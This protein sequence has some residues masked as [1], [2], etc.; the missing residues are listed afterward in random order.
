MTKITSKTFKIN[1]LDLVILAGGKGTRIK[2]LLKGYPKPMLKFNGK[3]FLQYI[4]NLVIKYP[5]RNIYILTGYKSKIIISKYDK[6]EINFVKIKCLK[7]KKLLG[8]GGALFTLKKKLSNFVLINGDTLF[9]IDYNKLLNTSFKNSFGTIALIGKKNKKSTK[10]NN[11]NLKNKIIQFDTRGKFMNGGVYFFK[12]KFLKLIP[13]I[14]SSLEDE[15]LPNLIKK[16]LINGVVYNNFFIDIGSKESLKIGAKKLNKHFY[17]PAAFLDRDGVINYDYGY[18]C[19]EKKFKIRKGVLKGLKHLIKNNYY[20]FIITNQAG[21]A[22]KKFSEKKFQNFQN[23]IKLK[24]SLKGIYFND[25]EYC[26][27]HPK[28]LLK[29]YK[30]RSDYRKPGNLMIKNLQKK[31][32]INMKKSF[33]IGDNITDKE[34]ANKSG[35]YFEYAKKDF[36]KQI[37]YVLRKN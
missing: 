5:F 6:K 37:K 32:L 30:K 27:Y 10:L 17:R 13:K 7:E 23:F 19:S 14:K 9:D 3:N 8:T 12:K 29:K 1:K 33:M 36:N 11:L 26:P 16:K 25:F 20:I 35:L 4:I 31:W 15:I 22:K 28:G 18:V 21:I 34:C 2:S 24:L